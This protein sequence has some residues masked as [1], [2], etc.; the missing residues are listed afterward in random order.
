L[1]SVLKAVKFFQSFYISY[2]PHPFPLPL[3]ERDLRKNFSIIFCDSLVF[4]GI[5]SIKFFSP[6]GRR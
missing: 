6:D 5:A 4:Y 3:R 2:P 1:K